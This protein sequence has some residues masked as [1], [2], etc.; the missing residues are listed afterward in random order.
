MLSASKASSAGPPPSTPSIEGG[1][2]DPATT[3]VV[4]GRTHRVYLATGTGSA[5]ADI[6]SSARPE[7][8]PGAPGI[9]S[10]ASNLPAQ[11][12]VTQHRAGPIVQHQHRPLAVGIRRR[13]RIRT[14]PPPPYRY[15]R[16]HRRDERG[17]A[18]HRCNPQRTHR[19]S[20]QLRQ[21]HRYLPRFYPPAVIGFHL[22][23]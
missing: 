16:A 6:V 22:P 12:I 19:F 13:P 18:T 2:L 11:S 14:T 3:V 15:T 4:V 8:L 20:G 23:S 5:A 7:P 9:R 1:Q 10:G 21:D 17:G